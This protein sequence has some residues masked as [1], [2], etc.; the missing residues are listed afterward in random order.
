MLQLDDSRF[1]EIEGP[2]QLGRRQKRL[3]NREDECADNNA[4]RSG[5]PQPDRQG[6]E[7]HGKMI[8]LNREP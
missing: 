7:A 6:T 4:V 3:T 5:R 8:L 1:L 2:R